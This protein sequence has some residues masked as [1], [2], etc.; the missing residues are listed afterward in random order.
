MFCYWMLCRNVHI[1]GLQVPVV[2]GASVR[3]RHPLCPAV[4]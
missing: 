4:E 3:L 2:I 1:G